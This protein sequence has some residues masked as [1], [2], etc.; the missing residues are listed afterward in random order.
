MF[1]TYSGFAKD[2]RFVLWRHDVD[3]S[4]HAARRLAEIEKE[5]GVR[6]TFFVNMHSEFYNIFEREVAD[7]VDDIIAMGHE[8][9]VHLDAAF[10]DVSAESELDDL[11]ARESSLLAEAFH[12][13]PSA[14]AFHN[15][16]PLLLGCKAWSYG[17]LV[18]TYSTYFQAEVGYCSDSNG[19]WRHRRLEDVLVS[20]SDPRLQVLTHPAWWQDEP[21]SPMARVNRCID[22]R[23]EKTRSMYYRMFEEHPDRVNVTDSST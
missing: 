20:A 8:L 11:V 22:G 5:E 4:A 21:M 2:E 13:T 23:A 16:T 10:Y 17:G 19:Y 9:G 7:C 15:P 14:V 12:V 6:S 3:F 1:R 18:N